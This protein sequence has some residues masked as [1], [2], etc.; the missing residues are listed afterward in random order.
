MR[1]G[2]LSS[3]LAASILTMLLFV[4]MWDSPLEQAAI[5]GVVWLVT[6]V[7]GGWWMTAMDSLSAAAQSVDST[8]PAELTKVDGQR[9]IT[10]QTDGTELVWT[11]ES[12]RKASLGTGQRLW[13]GSPAARGKYVLSVA[14]PKAETDDVRPT[15]LW[16]ADVAWTPG[17]WD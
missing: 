2:W 9:I 8:V 5:F 1:L 16:P 15:V 12:P 6:G 10:R 3:S 4:W 13:L 17:R 14:E 7:I 11:I